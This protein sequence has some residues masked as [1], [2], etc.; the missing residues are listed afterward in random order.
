MTLNIQPDERSFDLEA[1]RQI[2]AQIASKHDSV[3]G[4]STGRTTGNLHRA[5]ARMAREGSLD[6][7]RVT[8]F[9]QD[10]IVGVP[11]TYSGACYEMLRSELIGDLDIPEERFLMPPTRWEGAEKALRDFTEML[12]ARGGIDLIL[13]GL[14]E[15]GHLGF[16]QPG[17]PFG[18]TARIAT[19][20]PEL[21]A[22]VRRELALGP[23]APLGG[24]TL[25]LRDVMHA[26]RILLVAKG[27][28]KAAI[29]KEILQGPVT[30]AVPGSVLQLH[31]ACEYLLDAEAAALL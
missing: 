23:E 28:H 17:S 2:Y 7:S 21:D 15:N 18:G 27:S 25:G 24:A 6:L 12:Q 1:A 3:I 4:L 26:R 30:E 29:V 13:L 22:R 19:I 5:F 10:E 20:G 8:F 9:G 31:P 16:N 11:Q 14:G